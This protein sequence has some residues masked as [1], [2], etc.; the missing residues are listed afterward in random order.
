MTNIN[1]QKFTPSK[2]KRD[3]DGNR[4]KVFLAT[5]MYGGMC[6]G[7]FAESMMGL[8]KLGLDYSCFFM[9]NEALVTRARN[10]LVHDFLKSDCTHLLFVDA[11]IDFNPREVFEMITSGQDVVCGIYPK[12]YINWQA[13]FDTVRRGGSDEMGLFRSLDLCFTSQNPI[14][15]G[16]KELVEVDRAATG[17]MCIKRSVFEKL[18]DQVPSYKA[19]IRI[20]GSMEPEDEVKQFFDSSI[21]PET[22]L[23]E[24]EDFHFCRIWKNAGGKIHVAPWVCLKHVGQYTFGMDYSRPK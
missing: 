3:K 1:V 15:M 20:F 9:G 7:R 12:K 16:S 22:G 8:V 24:S 5:P 11:D 18:A 10:S 19:G 23:L 2:K 13:A 6:T 21:D 17:M 4:I 14:R